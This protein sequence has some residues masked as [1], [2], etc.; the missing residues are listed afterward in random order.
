MNKKL[1][2]R[3]GKQY[4]R[5]KNYLRELGKAEQIAVENTAKPC[6]FTEY[7]YFKF[8]NVTPEELPIDVRDY[9]M[10]LRDITLEPNGTPRMNLE[11]TSSMDIL[12]C[13]YKLKDYDMGVTLYLND[14]MNAAGSGFMPDWDLVGLG[15]GE[16]S[17]AIPK[18]TIN[19][20]FENGPG[21]IENSINIFADTLEMLKKV[22]KT[23]YGHEADY[24]ELLKYQITEEEFWKEATITDISVE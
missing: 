17:I 12:H 15:Y 21:I 6:K 16:I 7:L 14:Y 3:N 10:I 13:I 1:I 20:S 9:L 23:N 5:Y 24:K 19:I 11:G 2:N 22:I 4:L 8:A 18:Y